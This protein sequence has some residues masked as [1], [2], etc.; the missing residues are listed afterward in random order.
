MAS[1]DLWATPQVGALAPTEFTTESDAGAQPTNQSPST[2]LVAS[3]P[4]HRSLDV[5][6]AKTQEKVKKF[7][8][9]LEVMG[10]VEGPAVDKLRS[11]FKKLQSAAAVPTVSVQIEQVRG[12]HRK[13]AALVTELDTQRT[14]EME[15]LADSRSGLATNAS[16]T[17]SSGVGQ[18][19]VPMPPGTPRGNGVRRQHTGF[20]VEFPPF[21]WSSEV[22]GTH[23]PHDSVR[24]A[25]WS[26]LGQLSTLFFFGLRGVRIGEAKHPWTSSRCFQV[27]LPCDHC[28]V[29]K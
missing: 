1:G 29:V 12:V 5:A 25:Q 18:L 9:A 19:D 28:L 10:D 23:W 22:F 14:T 17:G 8:K 4:V 26:I 7:E 16:D 15:L 13:V 27:S 21:Q 3:L 24:L 6:R 2:K 20:G 11:E